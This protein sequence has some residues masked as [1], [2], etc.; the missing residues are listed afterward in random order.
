L[1]FKEFVCPQ[2]LDQ[3]KTGREARLFDGEIHSETSATRRALTVMGLNLR[4][5]LNVAQ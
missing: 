4:L 2:I 3:L 5:K 1:E